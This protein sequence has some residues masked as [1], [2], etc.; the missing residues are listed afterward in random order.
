MCSLRI[1]VFEVHFWSIAGVRWR[2]TQ[3]QKNVSYS[4]LFRTIPLPKMN[5]LLERW[6]TLASQT[7]K[8]LCF[9]PLSGWH[10]SRPLDQDR[11]HLYFMRVCASAVSRALEV[12]PFLLHFAAFSVDDW[13][14]WLKRQKAIESFWRVSCAIRATQSSS[15]PRTICTTLTVTVVSFSARWHLNPRIYVTFSRTFPLLCSRWSL[16]G[17]C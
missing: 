3:K 4:G 14:G 13:S 8:L 1:L 10:W 7:E 5:T 6:C 15:A 2:Q 16:S 17:R 9:L 11:S 12:E